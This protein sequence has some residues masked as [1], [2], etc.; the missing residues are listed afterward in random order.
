MQILHDLLLFW[1]LCIFSLKF[2]AFM[3]NFDLFSIDYNMISII[4]QHNIAES[5]NS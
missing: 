5:V 1:Y 4:Y 2:G 3:H